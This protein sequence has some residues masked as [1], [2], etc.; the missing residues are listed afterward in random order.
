MAKRVT[1]LNS[2]LAIECEVERQ[3]ARQMVGAGSYVWWRGSRA[4]RP[5]GSEI[6]IP[7][8]GQLGESDAEA[9]VGAQKRPITARQRERLIGWG[10][11][12]GGRA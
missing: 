10:L 11:L 6:S 5:L 2:D 12:P 1:V 3:I 9:L 7:S 8:P 4:I